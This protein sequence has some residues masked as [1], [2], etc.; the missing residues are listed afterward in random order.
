MKVSITI[1]DIRL[2]SNLNSNQTLVLTKKSSFSAKLG[3]NQSHSG[4][5]NGPPKGYIHF[6]RGSCKSDKPINIT[7]I[8]KF[9]LK[10]DCVNGS[11]VN[12]IREPILYSFALD[13]PPGHEIYKEPR[14]NFFKRINK[15]V[16]SHITFYLEDDDH[17]AVDSNG[18]TIYFTCQLMKI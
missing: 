1:D 14:I 11:S 12:G 18:E 4:S 5:L 8:D 13:K 2:K 3:F 16:L 9:P 15:S 6:I 10:C 7:G 17:K